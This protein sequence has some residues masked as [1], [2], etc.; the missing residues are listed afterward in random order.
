M[1]NLRSKFFHRKTTDSHLDRC[2]LIEEASSKI[3]KDFSRK[4]GINSG[5][6]PF[7]LKE[8]LL[9][10]AIQDPMRVL[11]ESIVILE[12]K[13]SLY[14]FI[15]INDPYFLLEWLNTQ[16]LNCIYHEGQVKPPVIEADKLKDDFKLL[17][18]A[19]TV[20]T[21]IYVF[22]D[23]LFLKVPNEKFVNLNRL[24]KITNICTF[25]SICT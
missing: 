5:S 14:H 17:L 10:S 25:I 23:I 3:K 18:T 15:F 9:D 19:S 12:I 21:L 1:K 20:L 11:L 16:L 24:I 22:P 6:I 7:N 13:A 4:Y 2:D 8:I